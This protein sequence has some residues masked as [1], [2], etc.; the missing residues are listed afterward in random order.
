[1]VQ[2]LNANQE[3][4]LLVDAASKV[5]ALTNIQSCI[6]KKS[7]LPLTDT[8]YSKDTKP[9]MGSAQCPFIMH[10]LLTTHDGT[11][12][13]WTKHKVHWVLVLSLSMQP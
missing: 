7:L 1:M 5:H 11:G 6:G 12:W 8:V 10:N 13:K 2:C 4:T 9:D 3:K